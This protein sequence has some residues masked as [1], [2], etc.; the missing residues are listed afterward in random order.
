MRKSRVESLRSSAAL[1]FVIAGDPAS[2]VERST[3]RGLS[4]D[5]YVNDVFFVLK[6]MDLA[7]EI[8]PALVV[9]ASSG[10]KGSRELLVRIATTYPSTPSLICKLIATQMPRATDTVKTLVLSLKP[11]AVPDGLLQLVEDLPS[12]PVNSMWTLIYQDHLRKK[13]PPNK[14]EN[15]VT[16]KATL[17]NH[18]TRF[19]TF[20]QMHR[21]LSIYLNMKTQRSS[22][23]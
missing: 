7:H 11:D 19:V 6:H 4:S 3:P 21:C 12:G 8:L 15:L 16:G 2:L 9:D 10:A 13:F 1:W 5:F 23:T 18:T 20:I 22:T 14:V 17:K